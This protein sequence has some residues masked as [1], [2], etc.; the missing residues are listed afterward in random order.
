ML[1]PMLMIG[2]AL[3]LAMPAPAFSALCE[4]DATAFTCFKENHRALLASDNDRYVQ[5]YEMAEKRAL[6][7]T[8]RSETAD[9]LDL[10]PYIGGSAHLGEVF[11]QSVEGLL[12]SNP[13]CFLDSALL[14]SD[15]SLS[16][17]IGDI[18]LTPTFHDSTAIQKALEPYRSIAKYGRIMKAYFKVQ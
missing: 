16:F 13:I 4:D 5:V 1:I 8:K 15:R 17:L 12:I 3:I 11:S 18:L 7:C 2:V 14:L 6:S 10:A 9:F